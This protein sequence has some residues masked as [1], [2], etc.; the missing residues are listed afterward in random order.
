MNKNLKGMKRTFSRR[1][2]QVALSGI[3]MLLTGAHSSS[4]QS[5]LAKS[6]KREVRAVWLTTIGGLD[7]P[8]VY[9]RSG[10]SVE[11]QK[12]EL[13]STLDKYQKAGINTLLIQTRI[14]GTMIYPSALEPWDGCLSGIPGKSPG[15]D[16]LQFAIN[17]AHSRGMEIHAWVVTLPVGKWNALGCSRL[18]KRFPSLIRKIG[19]EGY[20]NPEKTETA[21]YLADICE[22]ITRNYDID[23][24]HLDY[25]RYPETWPLKV[26]HQQ[27]RQYI[28]RIVQAIHDRVKT[29][30]PWVKMSCSPIGKFNDL[31]RYWSHGWNAYTK[32]CQD[33]Q[34]WLKSGLMDA[35]F[36][37][38]YFRDEQFYPFAIDWAEEAAGKI[39]APGLGIYL[40]SPKE[41]NWDASVITR[42]MHFLREYRLGHTYFRGQFLT[43]NLKGIYDFAANSFDATPALIPA[44]TWI[45]S[46][47]PNPPHGLHI[48]DGS[49]SWQPSSS[50]LVF[51]NIYSSRS[52]PVDIEDAQNLIRIR[53]NQTNI[54]L[55]TDGG[56]YYAVTAMDRYGNESVA[57]QQANMQAPAV[58]KSKLPMLACDGSRVHLPSPAKQN[59]ANVWLIESLQSCPIATRRQN[60]LWIDVRD[61]PCGI[62]I[63]KSLNRK[64]I[65]HRIGFFEIRR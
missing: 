62:Y 48:A 43:D 26:S 61:I 51:Y 53:Y 4:A 65:A 13:R 59:D 24:I 9:A 55:P 8:H 42:E 38:M 34:G 56:R 21:D 23:G 12:N 19:D 17:E 29:L 20:L 31:S 60:S 45:S 18:R 5:L 33:A 30:K 40:M 52:Y 14:R 16:A 64:G 57:L 11:S 39:V 22:E 25:I 7:W 6:P 49:V 35:L 1:V 50:R 10:S 41:R 36:P 15:Y 3:A 44:M 46:S 28:T 2:R 58:T 37:M 54:S 47:N 27:G 63:L 32:V